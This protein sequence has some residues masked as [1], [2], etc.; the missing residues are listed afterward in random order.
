MEVQPALLELDE[1]TLSCNGNVRKTITRDGFLSGLWWLWRK[2][3]PKDKTN[4]M[5]SMQ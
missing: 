1:Q 4:V 3:I 5:D 2:C